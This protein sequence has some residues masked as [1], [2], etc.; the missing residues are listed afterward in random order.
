MRDGLMR[1]G[2]LALAA[3]GCNPENEVG[4]RSQLDTFYQNP[5]DQVDILWVIDNSL[6]MSDEQAEVADKFSNFVTS[7]EETGM[8]FHIGVITTDMVTQGRAQLVGDPAVL[9]RDTPDYQGLFAERV[10]VGVDGSDREA[11]IDAA[12]SALSEP[13]VSGANAGFMRDGASLS[14]IYVSDENDCTDRGALS[15][16]TDALACYDHYDELVPVRDLIEDYEGLKRNDDRILVS[17]IVGPQVTA[18][19]N[20]A[21]P[22]FR[23]SSMAKAFGGVEGSICQSSFASIMSELGLQASGV[24]SSFQLT[25]AA[26]EDTIEVYINSDQVPGEPAE[27]PGE[28]EDDYWTKVPQSDTNGW[29]YDAEYAVLMMHGDAVPPRDSLVKVDYEIVPGSEN[30]TDTGAR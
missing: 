6:S 12:F 4:R 14:I 19:C 10:Q 3:A 21:T 26:V 8:D 30:F 7:I 28:E 9:T 20:G 11:G 23:Y 5:T 15:G 24:L 18:N 22:G 29:T 27:L 17:A 2:L 16:Y 1:L 13:L 25:Y